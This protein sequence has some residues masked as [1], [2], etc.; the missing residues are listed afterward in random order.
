M[1]VIGKIRQRAGLLIGLVGFSLAAFVLG[2]LFTSN[3][4]FLG[5]TDTNV[6]IIGDKKIDVRDFE[7]LV[8]ELTENYKINTSTETVDQN[9]LESLREQAWTELLNDEVFMKQ[10]NKTGLAVSSDEIFDMIQ[11]KNPHPQIK[12]AFT[13]PA[14]GEFSPANVI[15][16]LKNMDSDPTGAS[17][18]QWI[19]FEQYIKEERLKNKYNEMIKNGLFVTTAEA[20]QDYINKGKS[21][22]IRFI[23]QPYGSIVDSTITVT[24]KEMREYYN[25]HQNDFKQEASRKIEY[26]VFEVVPSE[27][28]R[29]K[30]YSEISSLAEEFNNTDNDSLFSAI[31]SDTKQPI[32]WY[33]EGQLSPVID[34]VFFS[35][36]A[37]TGMAYGPYEENKSFVIA[38]LLNSELRPDSLRVSHAL[39]SYAGSERAAPEITLTKAE[40]K[41]RADSLFNLIQSNPARFNEFASF[42]SDDKVS[43]EKGGDLDWITSESP[44]DPQF[45]KGAFNTKKGEVSLVESPFGFHLIKVTDQTAT[46]KQVEVAFVNRNIE[47]GSKTYQQAFSAANEFA[48]VYNTSESFEKGVEEKG[49]TKRVADNLKET[50][51]AIAGIESPRP[52]IV[53]AYRSNLHDISKAYEFGN[54][55]VVAHLADV[56]DKGIAPY[57]QVKDKLDGFVRTDN[58]AKI[59]IERF[60]NAMKGASGIDELATSMQTYAKSANNVNFGSTYIENL[61][62]EPALVATVVTMEKGKLSSPIKGQAGVYVAMVD[63]IN[64]PA[65]STDFSNNKNQLSSQ[66]KQRAT[67]EVF[68][69]LKEKANIVDN[70]GKFY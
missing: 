15:Q 48:G 47:P 59:L 27:E 28:D 41:E 20:Q 4:S 9:T 61:G 11:G 3:R 31:N 37:A 13:D 40:A 6:A 35:E 22:N 39:I 17:R 10:V 55:F 32:T 34:S 24:D 64:E 30:T 69:A 12:Q 1:A 18:A 38:K 25:S 46:S 62:V 49:L 51:K 42:Q 26:V 2:D 68:E 5:G 33:K 21:V 57:D 60:E 52:L 19:A 45:L 23:D 50:D 29:A 43:A 66:T 16:F 54:K 7:A 14:T 56:K 8:T 70:R 44:M 63:Q 67:Y 58:K 65:E 53:W 36:N